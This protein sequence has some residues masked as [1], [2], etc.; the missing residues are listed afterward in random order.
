V[1][2]VPLYKGWE[3]IGKIFG[4]TIAKRFMSWN[5]MTQ[6]P[7]SRSWSFLGSFRRSA[8]LTRCLEVSRGIF[9]LPS[10]QK[11]CRAKNDAFSSCGRFTLP[12]KKRGW[13]P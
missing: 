1:Q 7:Q 11:F 3:K 10:P 6:L 13:R 5:K 9:R 2:K 12:I 8:C 4:N